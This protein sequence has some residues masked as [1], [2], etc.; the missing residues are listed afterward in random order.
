[1]RDRA[2]DTAP[3]TFDLASA[4]GVADMTVGRVD[5]EPLAELRRLMEATQGLIA[6]GRFTDVEAYVRANAAFHEHMVALAGSGA[7]LDTYRRLSLPAIMGRLFTRFPAASEQ[8]LDDHRALV[9]AYERG[10]LEAAR[11]V[12]VAH[13]ERAKEANSAAI[14]AAGGVV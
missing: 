7:L 13:A 12:V 5:R 4:L 1:M 11:D 10:D 6:D 3:P 2:D 9:D 8:L 14:R